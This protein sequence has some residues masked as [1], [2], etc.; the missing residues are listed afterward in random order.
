MPGL[1]WGKGGI[2]EHGKSFLKL[3]AKEKN[4]FVC[5]RIYRKC[6]YINQA[7]LQETLIS[8]VMFLSHFIS[9][10]QK[11]IYRYRQQFG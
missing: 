4:S 3:S 11:Q 9:Y 2:G 6:G 5:L 8:Q 7:G 1:A 10:Q